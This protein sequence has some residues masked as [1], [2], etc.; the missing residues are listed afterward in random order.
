MSDKKKDAHEKAV[1][2]RDEKGRMLPMFN[3]AKQEHK[4]HLVADW[5]YKGKGF[6]ED[7]IKYGLGKKAK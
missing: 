1:W 3:G 2:K 5:D 7:E 6:T 4:Q